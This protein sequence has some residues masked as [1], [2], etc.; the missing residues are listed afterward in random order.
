V[1]PADLV[2]MRKIDE[3]HLEHPA[4]QLRDQLIRQGIQ[5]GWRHVDLL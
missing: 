1:S 2:L 3:L 4:R 5:V